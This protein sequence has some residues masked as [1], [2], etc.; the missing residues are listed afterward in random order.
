MRTQTMTTLL[1]L[2][3]LGASAVAS[4]R[5][6]QAPR[7]LVH[8]GRPLKARLWLNDL[9]KIPSATVP[10][11]SLAVS[12]IIPRTG[13]AY[14]IAPNVKVAAY[15][16]V[17]SVKGIDADFTVISAVNLAKLVHE[18]SVIEEFKKKNMGKEFASGVADGVKGI[19]TGIASLITHPGQSFKTI[20]ERLRQTGRSLE[21]AVGAED[22]IGPDE[23][24]R[25]RAHLGEGPAGKA[26]RDTAH[27]FG[28]DVYTDNPLMQK[29]LIDLSHAY[30]AGSYATWIIPYSIGAL[31]Y[32]N[33]I[34]GD[35]VTE[36]IIRDY[37][38]YELRRFIGEELEPILRMN[39]ED[40]RHPLNRWLANPNYS[41]RCV[42]YIGRALV[43]LRGAENLA[44]VVEELAQASTPEEADML[45][46]EVRM[47]GLFQ[48]NV[49][50]IVDFAKYRSLFIGLGADRKMHIMFPGDTIRPW[51]E[52]ANAFAE[53]LNEARQRGLAGM[54]VWTVGD[55]HP[56]M[57]EQAR[58]FGVDVRQN[59][60]RDEKFYRSM[61]NP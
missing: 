31:D 40:S 11:Q 8:L 19:G 29:W 38:P 61:K 56:N 36:T 60:L 5:P 32:F 42:A 24:G 53:V 25:K 20:G 50:P 27:Q 35:E 4:E 47:Y 23:S 1:C 26:R 52:T 12:Q 13:E 43:A 10:Y 3:L 57:L 48:R 51:D 54:E 33:P 16:Y 49:Q 45:T 15:S 9:S 22:K 46:L 58:R 39:R 7:E 2:A 21:R 28:I 41:P 44:A 30:T 34:S 59:V 55:I 17:F 37:A 6:A 14:R 18:L